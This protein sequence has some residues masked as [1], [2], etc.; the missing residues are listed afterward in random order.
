[1]YRW[2]SRELTTVACYTNESRDNLR[3]TKI[4]H[5]ETVTINREIMANHL[6]YTCLYMFIVAGN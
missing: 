6:A 1:M 4:G 3:M 5:N 2:L